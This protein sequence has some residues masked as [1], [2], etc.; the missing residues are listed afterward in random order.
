[1]LI[2]GAPLYQGYHPHHSASH[3]HHQPH[4]HQQPHQTNYH[5]A[6]TNPHIGGGHRYRLLPGQPP[7]ADANVGGKLQVKMGYDPTNQQL[8]VTVICASALTLR[9]DG[10]ARNP[11]AKVY[12]LPDRSEKSK[13]RTKTLASTNEPRWG[14][15][16]RYNGYRRMDLC[17]RLIEV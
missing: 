15:I 14:Q 13:R 2:N 3:Q 9:A 5:P 16:F 10:S 17:N 6:F 7:V 4:H 8:V 11:Y 12:L 1:M